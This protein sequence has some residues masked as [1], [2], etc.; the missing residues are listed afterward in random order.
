MRDVR[1]QME[2]D[3]NLRVLMQ[4][5]RGSNLSDADFAGGLLAWVAGWLV[6]RGGGLLACYARLGGN[7]IARLEVKLLFCTSGA[8]RKAAGRVQGC[9]AAAPLSMLPPLPGSLCARS[10]ARR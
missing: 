7:G 6:K 1:A 9:D 3:E 10:P 4:S 8:A 2:E 5:L